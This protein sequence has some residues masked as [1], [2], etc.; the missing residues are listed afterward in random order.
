MPEAIRN[1]LERYANGNDCEGNVCEN[2][3]LALERYLGKIEQ[4]GD[5]ADRRKLLDSVVSIG[6]P[7]VYK[8]AYERW[9]KALSQME[10]EFKEFEV[11][12][13]L[14]VGLG[15]ESVLETSITLNRIYGVPIIP[16]SALK[17][18]TRRYYEQVVGEKD[19]NIAQVLFGAMPKDR[20]EDDQGNAGFVIFYDVWYVPE[21]NEKPLC[22]DVITVHHPEYYS[23][24]GRGAAP[25]DFDNPNPVPFI[26]ARGK[27]LVALGL[28]AECDER[29]EWLE[30][31]F[32]LVEDALRDYGVGA[33]TSSGYGR[34]EPA[35]G[36][37]TGCCTQSE[38]AKQ[39]LALTQGRVNSDIGSYFSKWEELPEGPEKLEVAI[40]FQ[41]RLEQA[42]LLENKK[43]AT[44]PWVVTVLDYIKAHQ[45]QC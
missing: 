17:G 26:S 18:L 45:D 33:K 30:C 20:K 1:R 25:T 41:K 2:A 34:L 6:V 12:D 27:F 43:W 38:I 44:K 37:K 10:A 32:K 8:A 39:I 36:N 14:I 13:R 3:G 4:G 9:K 11:K 22:G 23:K 28:D 29:K 24:A 7:S 19:D 21:N 42:G 16:G 35:A 40:A 5:N 31:A 15:S